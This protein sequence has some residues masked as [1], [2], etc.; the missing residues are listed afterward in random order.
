MEPTVLKSAAKL[1]ELLRQPTPRA[2]KPGDEKQ[3]LRA[4]FM[5]IGVKNDP[6]PPGFRTLAEWAS[7]CGISVGVAK[8]KLY[9][10]K[11]GGGAVR[12]QFRTG[13]R[14]VVYYSVP[15]FEKLRGRG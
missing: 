7:L 2:G 12:R 14:S 5:Q 13:T 4:L 3:E 11:R 8:R 15:Q 9:W 6:I 10:L 1:A